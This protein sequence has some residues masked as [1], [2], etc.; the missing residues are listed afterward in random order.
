MR[1][2]RQRLL[3]ILRTGGLKVVSVPQPNPEL[4]LL[5]NEIAELRQ[6][7]KIDAELAA[8]KARLNREG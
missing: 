7:D 1:Q 3:R 6:S 2:F 8:L 5:V 4:D